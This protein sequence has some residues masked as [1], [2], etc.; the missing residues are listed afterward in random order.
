MKSVYRCFGTCLC[1]RT[2]VACDLNVYE[3]LVD[4]S[5]RDTRAPAEG[6]FIKRV[7]HPHRHL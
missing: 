5:T 2:R 4:E 1:W 7:N 6:T 3:Q